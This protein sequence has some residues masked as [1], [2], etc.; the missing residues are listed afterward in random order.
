MNE[1]QVVGFGW[2]QPKPNGSNLLSVQTERLLTNL[3]LVYQATAIASV[4]IGI[5]LT[6]PKD[7]KAAALTDRPNINTTNTIS[8]DLADKLQSTLDQNLGQTVGATVGITSPFGNWF[9]ASGVNN[10]ETETVVT[11]SDRFPIGSITKTFTATTIL[12]LAEKGKLSLEDTLGKWLPN[13]AN[14]I[15]NSN[16]ITIR[17]ILNGTSG[18]GDF[19]GEE[20]LSQDLLDN[21]SLI[22]QDREPEELVSYVYDRPL[23]EGSRCYQQV[24]WC[25]PNTG[26][27]LAGLIIE[28]ATGSNIA[29]EIRE[30]ILTPL[31][32]NDTFFAEE[33]EIPGGYVSG[34]VNI[35]NEFDDITEY[36]LS[37]AWT[38]GGLVSNTQD[39]TRFAQGLFGGELLQPD[40][41]AQMLTFV[42]GGEG[43]RYGLGVIEVDTGLGTF[44]GHAGDIFGYNSD[45]WYLPETEVIYTNL[46]NTQPSS[47]LI[48]PILTTLVAENAQSVPESNNL[49]SLIIFLGVGCL[50]F[51][52]ERKN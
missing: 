52:N 27:I 34:Y 51:S 16:E 22:F 42:D 46:Q 45:M 3:K 15:P 31:G 49:I 5:C 36:N 23:F 25:Y 19:L 11:P 43:Y 21:P 2:I 12:Q 30:G 33:E 35:N 48:A 17:Q 37:L 13:I 6:L 10:L 41:L 20:E 26:Y 50:F 18:I 14:N 29:E 9:G 44:L 40:S 24:Q 38:A 4:A 1:P 39:L 32:M 28:E 8:S 47:N 7:A